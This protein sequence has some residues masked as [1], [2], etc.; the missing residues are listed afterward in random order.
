MFAKARI[1]REQ[2][3][4]FLQEDRA[5]RKKSTIAFDVGSWQITIYLRQSGAVRFEI[6]PENPALRQTV[7]TW[8]ENV[9]RH[10][11]KGEAFRGIV[12]KILPFGVFVRLTP[13]CEGLLHV[14]YMFGGD[15]SSLS[16]GQLF[17]VA[18]WEID[19]L[20]HVN[21]IMQPA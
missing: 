14:A 19:S 18:V 7:E 10:V 2:A 13:D 17:L 12:V 15:C 16:F 20:G 1:T 21:L 3:R 8:L 5:G 11:K 4:Q 9:G 6:R